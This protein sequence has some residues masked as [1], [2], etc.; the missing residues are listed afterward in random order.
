VA[1]DAKETTNP[2]EL[3]VAEAIGGA[4]EFWGFKAIM[5]RLW[6]FLYLSPEPL[7]QPE[8]AER[9]AVSS[10]SIS[11]ALADLQKWGVV[12]KAWRPGDRK[13]FYEAET[14][15]WKMVSRVFREREL[16][17]IR[18]AIV[19]FDAAKRQLGDVR[20]GAAPETKRRI[21]FIEGRLTTL[22]AL[23]RVAEGLLNLLLAGKS[24]DLSP[25]KS[26][27]D[28]GDKGERD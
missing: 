1:G 25:L 10:G 11:M 21:K 24:V 5:G 3:R 7:S 19:A 12:K 16:V 23:S 4:I 17:H 27:F 20:S 9:L 26:L 8:L 18:E 15:I 22:L 6:T 28:S 14:S 13:D 2:I